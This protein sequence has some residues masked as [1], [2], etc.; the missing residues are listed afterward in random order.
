MSFAKLL[1]MTPFQSADYLVRKPLL[2]GDV[3]EDYALN[4]KFSKSFWCINLFQQARV[5][6]EEKD[7][8]SHDLTF[9]TTTL[10]RLQGHDVSSE[11]TSLTR[12]K[13][14]N[15]R[16]KPYSSHKSHMHVTKRVKFELIGFCKEH[17]GYTSVAE[18]PHYIS[19]VAS[20]FR[21]VVLATRNSRCSVKHGQCCALYS[22]LV[23]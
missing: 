12:P 8:N 13:P 16:R 11:R 17:Y 5:L 15:Q 3:Y 19:I 9:H 20:V 18:G 4:K 23:Q 2:N 22:V 1:N 14:R 10:L 6:R 21:Y 7:F